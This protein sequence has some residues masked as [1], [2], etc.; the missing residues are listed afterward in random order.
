VIRI[1]CTSCQKPLSIDETK[2][3]MKEVAFPC[4]VCKARLTV[5]RRTLGSAAAEGAIAAPS[6][7]AAAGP[8]PPPAPQEGTADAPSLPGAVSPLLAAQ[9]SPDLDSDYG[10]RALIVGTDHPAL[11]SAAASIGLQPVHMATAEQARDYYLQEFPP[12][13][14]LSPAQ[15]T[16]PP[17]ESMQPMI[18]V[19]SVDR[20]RS[21]FILVAEGLR[22]L[23]GNAAFLYGVNVIISTRD[24]ASFPRIYRDAHLYH[25]RLYSAMTSVQKNLHA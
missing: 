9:Q 22:T 4:P 12:V 10:H 7:V 18:S 11:R 13:V 24:L 8:V 20:R 21:F 16:A 2:L 25:E 3:P 23:D 1:V 15:L 6:P 5:D 14:I 17:I 19:A